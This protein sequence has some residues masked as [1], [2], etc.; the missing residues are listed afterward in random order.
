[1]KTD[2]VKPVRKKERINMR[3]KLF[4]NGTFITMDEAIHSPEA[5]LVSDGIIE[6]AGNRMELESLA[7]DAERMDLGGAAVLP[8][9]IDGHSH[10]TA[11]ASNMQLANLKTSP[12]GDCNSMEDLIRILKG[13]LE[14]KKEAGDLRPGGWILGMGYDNV[15]FDKA[16]HPGTKELDQVSTEYPVAA[17]HVS[18]H[19]C[20]VNTKAMELLGY[21]GQDISI[22]AGGFVEPG[23][24]LKENAFLSPTKQKIMVSALGK[25]MAAAIGKAS[26]YYASYGIT[27]A[28][29]ARTGLED[30]ESLQEAGKRGLL[31]ND[32][33]LYLAPDAAEELLPRQNPRENVYKNR[34]RTAGYK[35]FLDGSPQGKTAWLSKPYYQVPEGEEED[36]CGHPVLDDDTVIGV[37][38]LCMRNHWQINVHANG[39]EAIEQMIRC[40]EAAGKRTGADMAGL[41]PVMIHCQTARRDQIERMGRNGILASFFDDHVYYWGDYHYESVLGPDRAEHISPLSWALESGVSFTLHQDS[42]VTPPDMLFSVHNAVNRRTKGGRLLGAGHRITVMEALRAVTINGA[43]QIFEEQKKGSITPG[44]LADFVILDRNPLET[45]PEK[46]R[47]IQ[48]L[49]TIKEGETVYCAKND[50]NLRQKKL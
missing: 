21:V 43:R 15:A 27:T 26:E 18:G 13:F 37:M 45:P 29:D 17:V 34:V 46:I 2:G 35:M 9:F 38:E 22:P 10:L 36:Y 3:R 12:S 19:I 16:R 20:A 28:Q 11:V 48:V 30:Y 4:Y 47:E 14:K 8:G 44:K 49:A 40:Q 31:K 1:M 39:D 50:C 6:A 24:L 5:V 23:G 32:V 42:P 33:A 7:P 25:D 41:R